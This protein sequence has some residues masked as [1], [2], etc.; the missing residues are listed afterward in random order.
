MS[1]I[2]KRINNLY[3]KIDLSKC[4][5]VSQAINIL[6]ECNNVKFIESVD[7]AI[8]L[9]INTKKVDQNIRNTVVLP[10][11][12]GKVMKIAVFTQDKK[13]IELVKK[14]GISM[15]GMEE[16]FHYIKN[17][18]RK[19][20]NFVIA[21][22]D[23]MPLVSKLGSI[24]GPRN[25]MPNPKLGTVTDDVISVINEIKLGKIIYCND[26][27]GIIHTSIGRINFNKSK[28]IENLKTLILSIIKSKF[29]LNT[30][31]LINQVHLSTTM[32]IGININFLNI[33]KN[34]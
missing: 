22:P 5:E 23:A 9:N 8:K 25:I 32:G 2:N 27:Y 20:I 29:I 28:I 1:R 19:K 13:Q 24:L 18:K 16:L 34:K 31:N 11:N 21:S 30:N 10:H 15:V 17:H 4:Y 14:I 3:K 26:K 12:N 33:L 7:V 6:K